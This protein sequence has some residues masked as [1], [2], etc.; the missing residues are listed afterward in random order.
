MSNPDLRIRVPGKPVSS[1]H[2][3]M[4]IKGGRLALTPAAIAW[5]A[6]ICLK[7]REV[8][9][10]FRWA[11]DQG[12]IGMPLTVE[13]T[14]YG[15]KADRDNLL[16]CTIDGLKKGLGID[17]KHFNVTSKYPRDK[18]YPDGAVIEIWASEVEG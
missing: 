18:Q 14:H 12:L 4:R 9:H 16:K 3:Y 10:R 13:C 17:D 8:T 1:N 7:V 6:M 15:S 11:I 5:Q 2:M